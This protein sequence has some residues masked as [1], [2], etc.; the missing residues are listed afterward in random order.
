MILGLWDNDQ[1]NRG[2]TVRNAE[3]KRYFTLD[4]PAHEVIE[5]F[6]RWRGDE[7]IQCSSDTNHPTE[8][9]LPDDFNVEVWLNG[10]LGNYNMKMVDTDALTVIYNGFTKEYSVIINDLKSVKLTITED[11]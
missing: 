11:R 4:C 5:F 7:C 3:E 8:Y 2:V 10:K 1:G 9:G 6:D